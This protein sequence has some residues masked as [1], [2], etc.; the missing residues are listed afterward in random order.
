MRGYNNYG[1]CTLEVSSIGKV[2]VEVVQQ[3]GEPDVFAYSGYVVD[4]ERDLTDAELD[5]ITEK[6]Q[7]ALYDYAYE[8]SF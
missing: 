8:H 2:E 3:K 6:Y 4:T 5:T 1:F 7:Y